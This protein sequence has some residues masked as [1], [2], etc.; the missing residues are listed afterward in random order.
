M[1]KVLIL[2]HNREVQKA[3]VSLILVILILVLGRTCLESIYY[4]N[5][6]NYPYNNPPIFFSIGD[7]ISAI[8]ILVAVYQFRR[9]KWVVALQVRSYIMPTITVCTILAI[10]VSICSSLTTFETPNNIFQL[11]I[12]WQIASSVL[13]LF[14]ILLLLLKATNKNLFNEKTSRKFYE[15]LHWEISRPGEGLNTALNALLE[16]FDN[17]CKAVSENPLDSDVSKSGRAILDVILSDRSL[18]EL[19]STK[20]L[21]GLLHII[22]VIEKYNINSRH[23]PKGL[24]FIV[25]SLFFNQN[26]FLYK[27][28]DNS[29]L[30]LSSNIYQGLFESPTILSNFDLFGYPT[31]SYSAKS[32]TDTSTVNVF[33]QAV[34]RAVKTYLKEGGIPTRQINHGIKHLSGIFE[35]LC[36]KLSKEGAKDGSNMLR[37]EYWSLNQIVDFFGH[38]YVYMGNDEE[39]NKEVT[40]IEKTATDADFYSHSTINSAVAAAM[41]KILQSLSRLEKTEDSYHLVIQLLDGIIHEPQ[42]KKGYAIPFEKR[43][44]QQ[45][46]ANVLG[47]HYPMVLRPYLNYIGFTLAA[48]GNQLGGWVGEQAEKMRRLLYVDLKPQLDNDEKMVDGRLMK[49]VLLP[50]SMD[51]KNG[52]FIYTMGFGRGPVKEIDEPPTGSLSALN[53]IDWENPRHL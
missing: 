32:S 13:I 38:D 12:F 24:P 23:S 19:L 1:H 42:Y 53:G 8:A 11:S 46:G 35:E 36:S 44:W 51:Y 10:L 30:A 9:E 22:N 47:R 50:D 49:E 29:G 52:K 17:I 26:S 2:L 40:D 14:S 28:L 18:G 45:I 43:L 37:D 33:I 15:V 41:Y 5:N 16:N 48:G 39:L 3:I 21:D 25:Q 27:H 20:R 31:I 34:S 4:F 6:V 7:A